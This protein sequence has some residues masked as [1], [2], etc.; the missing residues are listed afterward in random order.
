MSLAVPWAL[1]L[2]FPLGAMWLLRWRRAAP[3]A[4]LRV[5][6]PAAHAAAAETRRGWRIRTRHLPTALLVI[7]ATL[8]VVAAAG[9][10]RGLAVTTLPEDGIDVALALDISGSMQ[11][12]IFG[13]GQSRLDAAEAVIDDFVAGLEGDRVGL[14]AFRAQPLLMSPLTLDHEALRRSV[15][16]ATALRALPEG[17]A[18]G[19]GLA[20]SVNLLR[21]SPALSRV[22]VLLTDG[23]NNAGDLDPAEA[24]QL[25]ATLGVRV[26]TIGFQGNLSGAERVDTV[27]LRSVAEITGGEFYLAGTEEALREAYGEVRTL[28]RSRVGERRF[29]RFQSFAPWLGGAALVLIG[30]AQLG[31]AT[32]WRRYP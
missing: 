21:D 32:L 31:Q 30:L 6:H 7:A 17:T 27:A 23:A 2:L 12:R 16:D 3:R 19:L 10:R 5:A 14:V 15:A 13:E 29:T 28:E 24:A 20:E 4:A 22:V 11:Q 8:L 9:P 26:Y 1:T 25:A 18:I